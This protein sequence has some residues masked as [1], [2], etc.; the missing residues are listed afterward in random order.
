MAK[1]ALQRKRDQRAKQRALGDKSIEVNLSSVT[2]GRLEASIAL[3][4]PTGQLYSAAEYI[5]LLILE[6]AKRVESMVDDLLPCVS[7]R[8]TYPETC[9]GLNKGDSRCYLTNEHRQRFAFRT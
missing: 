7:C 2:Q 9:G 5:T 3:R 8:K 1:S 6:D 4:S